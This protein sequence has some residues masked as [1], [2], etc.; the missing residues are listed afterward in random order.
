MFE[1]CERIPRCLRRGK[2][3]QKKLLQRIE[4]SSPLAARSFNGI[5]ISFIK[6]DYPLI[7]NV[8][9]DQNFSMAG[10]E[11]ISAM[12]L[13]DILSRG[14]KKDFVDLFF[15]LKIFRL[16]QTFNFYEE[17]FKTE[18]YQYTLMRSLQYFTDADQDPLPKMKEPVEWDQV[19][20]FITG[21]VRK[22]KLI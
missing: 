5:R 6:Y 21:E 12:K 22:I 9:R 20:E 14:T 18:G 10:L 3:T 13:S 16:K 8:I 1:S 11:D 7:R 4:D 19:R 17:K 2:R 15:L